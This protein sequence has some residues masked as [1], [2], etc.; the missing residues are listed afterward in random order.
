MEATEQACQCNLYLETR[1]L[2]RTWGFNLN[3]LVLKHAHQNELLPLVIVAFLSELFLRIAPLPYG[4]TKQE[5][6]F[7]ASSHVPKW[8]VPMGSR[9]HSS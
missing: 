5:L 4:F 3:H 8:T 9:Q 7:L 6:V 1:V 2:G